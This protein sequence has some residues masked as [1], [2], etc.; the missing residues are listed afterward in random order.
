MSRF[1]RSLA[2]PAALPVMSVGA[3]SSLASVRSL[4]AADSF[5]Y[6]TDFLLARSSVS[7]A[8]SVVAL[9]A[10]HALAWYVDVREESIP[11]EAATTRGASTSFLPVVSSIVSSGP[12]SA[13]SSSCCLVAKLSPNSGLHVTLG[14]GSTTIHSTSA[15][16]LE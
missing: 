1:F 16:D 10:A 13:V 14:V 7:P 11:A 4:V 9:D 5:V 12:V 2:G 6:A 8:V 3:S 15:G